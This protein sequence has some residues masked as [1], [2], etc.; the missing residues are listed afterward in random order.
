MCDREWAKVQWAAIG[1]CVIVAFAALTGCAKADT[2]ADDN[3]PG[4][5]TININEEGTQRVNSNAKRDRLPVRSAYRAVHGSVGAQPVPR[6]Q[7][8]PAARVV[9]AKPEAP[10][11][12]G[13]SSTGRIRY[14]PERGA[15]TGRGVSPEGTDLGVGNS[16]VEEQ[17]SPVQGTAEVSKGWPWGKLLI[18][19]TVFF[20]LGRAVWDK[21]QDARVLNMVGKD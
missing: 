20:F 19:F 14:S 11:K 3:A 7:A 15:A 12:A 9:Q 16:R 4:Y 8:R 21:V 10:R 17:A 6:P 5:N 18:C 2:P 13:N 1:M